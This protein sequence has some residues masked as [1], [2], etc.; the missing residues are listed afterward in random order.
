[1][2]QWFISEAGKQTGP[3]SASDIRTMIHQGVIS[4]TTLVWSEGMPEWKP[5]SDVPEVISEYAD[6]F[7]RKT[8]LN[9]DLTDD[10]FSIPTV[11][12]Q[13][14]ELYKTHWLNLSV[15]GFV[16]TV[17]MV[18][19]YFFPLVG[20]LIGLLLGGLL[21]VGSF[22][23]VLPA[24]DGGDVKVDRLFTDIAR[25]EKWLMWALISL[26][27]SLLGILILP[28]ALLGFW[29]PLVA[30]RRMDAFAALGESV[31]LAQKH[32]VAIALLVVVSAVIVFLGALVLVVGSAF[33]TGF[34]IG[35]WAIVY[36]KLSPKV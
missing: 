32:L 22:K 24:V 16:Y 7:A 17:L 26:I 27:V 15:I 4:R 5:A 3:V 34:V 29:A 11:L 23:A 13:S 8:P 30:D 1:M 21:W 12:R 19:N 20:S 35:L 25:F 14:A 10:D 6:I 28:L 2:K 33:A 18:L 9:I 31:S 36:R